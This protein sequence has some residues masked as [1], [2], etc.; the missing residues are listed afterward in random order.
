MRYATRMTGGFSLIEIMVVVVIIGL[1]ATIAITQFGG[2]TD[3]ARWTGTKALIKDLKTAIFSF[4]EHNSGKLPERLEDLLDR[5]SYA[6]KWMG[7]YIDR[8]P[9]DLWDRKLR[10]DVPSRYGIEYD[11]YSYGA[12]DAEGGEG[13]NEDIY[14]HE[15]WKKK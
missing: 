11:L 9:V 3:E 4:K 7:P 10:Y 13:I 2:K 14:N 8:E 15:L 1:L 6:K 5:P 12:D